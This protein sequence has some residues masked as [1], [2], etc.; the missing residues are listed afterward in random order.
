MKKKLLV[1]IL[2][3]AM[4]ATVVGAF[5]GCDILVPPAQPT[6]CEHYGLCGDCF[7]LCDCQPVVGGHYQHQVNDLQNRVDALYTSYNGESQGEIDEL[8]QLVLQLIQLLENQTNLNADIIAGLQAQIDALAQRVEDLEHKLGFVPPNPERHFVPFTQRINS[9]FGSNLDD[10]APPLH[11]YFENDL[12][13]YGGGPNA[14]PRY[15]YRP[16]GTRWEWTAWWL[17]HYEHEVIFGEEEI[18]FYIHF[19]HPHTAVTAWLRDVE[20]INDTLVFNVNRLDFTHSGE[21]GGGAAITHVHI[22][23]TIDSAY[24]KNITRYQIVRRDVYFPPRQL[25]VSIKDEHMARVAARDFEAADFGPLVSE[26][27]FDIW[28][29][30]MGS[31]FGRRIILHASLGAT[32]VLLDHLDGLSFVYGRPWFGGGL[33]ASVG[34]EV[35]VRIAPAYYDRFDNELFSIADF[36]HPMLL[37]ILRF[38][39]PRTQ[40]RANIRLTLAEPSTANLNHLRYFVT[41]HVPYVE[42]AEWSNR[43]ITIYHYRENRPPPVQ[44]VSHYHSF[45]FLR[46]GDPVT[47]RSVAELESYINTFRLDTSYQ[48]TQ[49]FRKYTDFLRNSFTVGFF[50]HNFIV[51]VGFLSSIGDTFRITRVCPSGSIFIRR[52][53]SATFDPIIHGIILEL[54][55]TITTTNFS[56]NINI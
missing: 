26:I 6:E 52:Q 27:H 21:Y 13:T 1:I 46:T 18:S 4:M 11:F 48:T 16:D 19:V 53:H 20:I 39:H 51:L 50:E 45:H 44:F 55:N 3:I 25:T 2:A 36:N 41:N 33:G 23:A 35:G 37:S 54:P 12:Y 29:R 49:A 17:E 15:G 32:D 24:T 7:C 10:F 42:A 34:R 8:K 5:T 14:Q 56:V 47:I 31:T 30:D 38:V 43:Y 9:N 22:L 28:D 40:V